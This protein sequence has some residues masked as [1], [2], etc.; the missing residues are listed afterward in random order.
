MG[1]QQTRQHNQGHKA[2][3]RDCTGDP[4]V[5]EIRFHSP[6][7]GEKNGYVATPSA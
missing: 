2:G 4:Q 5:E 1:R 6:S 7:I 3:N